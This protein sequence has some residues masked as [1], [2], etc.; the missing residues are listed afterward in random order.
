MQGCL[1]LPARLGLRSV[2]RLEMLWCGSFL[3][4]PG[5]LRVLLDLV[6]L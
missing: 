6:W 5:C 4:S 1:R 2:V 3:P